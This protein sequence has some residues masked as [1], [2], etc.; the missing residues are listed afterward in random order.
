MKHWMVCKYLFQYILVKVT[1]SI[2]CI[3][4]SN[5]YLLSLWHYGLLRTSAFF[6]TDAHSSP[7]FPFYFH[8]FTFNSHSTLWLPSISIRAVPLS[9]TSRFT[10]KNILSHACFFHSDQFFNNFTVVLLT[11]ILGVLHNFLNLWSYYTSCTITAPHIFLKKFFSHISLT[12]IKWACV[13][14]NL[15]FT[16]FHTVAPLYTKSST[17][18]E[19]VPDTLRC[20]N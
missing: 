14:R 17:R 3:W 19:K 13:S 20:P 9:S 11:T 10:L 7:L 8:L 2:F 18:A 1:T 12:C 16:R 4:S 5:A 15:S 6:I